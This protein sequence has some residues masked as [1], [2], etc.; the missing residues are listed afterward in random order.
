MS[1]RIASDGFSGVDTAQLGIDSAS[2]FSP[3]KASA[4]EK[5]LNF[6]ISSVGDENT[7]GTL[8]IKDIVNFQENN[9]FQLKNENDI[10][11]IVVLDDF[12]TPDNKTV[13]SNFKGEDTVVELPTSHG[14]LVVNAIEAN[15]GSQNSGNYNLQKVHV[16]SAADGPDK[17]YESFSNTIDELAQSNNPPDYVNISYNFGISYNNLSNYASAAMGEQVEVTKDNVKDMMPFILKGM[18]QQV[19]EG[20]WAEKD[21]AILQSLSELSAKGTKIYI[22]AGNNMYAGQE[23]VE[24]NLLS[25]AASSELDPNGNISVVTGTRDYQGEL[26]RGAES[27]EF[28]NQLV[29]D[30]APSFIRFEKAK[31]GTLVGY[32]GA[33]VI[34][35]EI[36]K[37]FPDNFTVLGGSSSATPFA[38]SQD[39]L[40]EFFVE[41]SDDDSTH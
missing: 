36:A 31:D 33:G 30:R 18:K 16:A 28:E 8:S 35:S 24:A 22:G 13:S 20:N 40:S 25:L 19:S 21:L 23:D 39:V 17:T 10:P 11:N 32:G 6:E 4:F 38:L 27:F 7:S 2:S 9:D 14:E 5:A 1:L 34:S 12:I 29:T 15:L 26:S 41:V 3:F 37:S